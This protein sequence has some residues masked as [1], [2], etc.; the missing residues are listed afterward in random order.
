M[1]NVKINE[2]GDPVDEFG[3]PIKSTPPQ[4][5]LDQLLHNLVNTPSPNPAPPT[6]SQ[7]ENDW[8]NNAASAGNFIK[9][10][11]LPVTGAV[12][13]GT[14]GAAGGGLIGPGG[15]VPGAILGAGL[16]SATGEAA[17]EGVSS[18]VNGQP[19]KPNTKSIVTQGV[20]GSLGEGAGRVAAPIIK[21]VAPSIADY[22]GELLGKLSP[23]GETVDVGPN[24][25]DLDRLMKGTSQ[26][27]IEQLG[28]VT[29]PIQDVLQKGRQALQAEPLPAGA[30]L[31]P[32]QA[33][34]L[35]DEIHSIVLGQGGEGIDPQIAANIAAEGA[36]NT[37][38]FN[39]VRAMKSFK[40]MSD[41]QIRDMIKT[42]E[43]YQSQLEN[44]ARRFG[45]NRGTGMSYEDLMALKPRQLTF[46][47]E[48]AQSKTGLLPEQQMG[49]LTNLGK[50]LGSL[51][52][53]M[54]RTKRFMPEEG[55]N[56]EDYG[57]LAPMNLQQR[58][59][60][61]LGSLGGQSIAQYLSNRLGG[62]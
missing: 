60:E 48:L 47:Q 42:P 21:S 9:K 36:Q 56:P 46:L 50:D 15:I 13:G 20:V 25:I 57:F 33:Q 16:G 12:L 49:E 28:Q 26:Q 54:Q 7:L 23:G 30:T 29:K 17:N 4:S 39:Q 38:L 34:Q 45:E 35:Q 40:R 27:Q 1:A 6:V 41:D 14:A 32:A 44:T 52:A 31:T 8:G 11:A 18:L 61:M 24:S 58:G 59:S 62:K 55:A 53:A 51:Q 5:T 19:F 37:S 43:F 2:F 10:N 22:M 3:D